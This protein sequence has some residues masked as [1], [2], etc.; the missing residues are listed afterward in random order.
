MSKLT[1]GIATMVNG[2]ALGL[3]NPMYEDRLHNHHHA[4]ARESAKHK[5]HKGV[6]KYTADGTR[7]QF[8]SP[9]QRLRGLEQICAPAGFATAGAS[10]LSDHCGIQFVSIY[11]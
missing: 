7:G 8:R 3:Q 2:V 10:L 4:N 1:D 6:N 5:R 9:P 11:I